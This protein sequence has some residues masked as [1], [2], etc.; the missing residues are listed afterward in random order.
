YYINKNILDRFNFSYDQNAEVS[1]FEENNHFI[2][3][4]GHYTYINH[5][6]ENNLLETLLKQFQNS[7][8]SFL[9]TLDYIGGRYVV[10]IGNESKVEVYP[11]ATSSRTT[12]YSEDS[13][14]ASSHANLL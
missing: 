4:H 10:V 9:D 8:E 13:I 6:K 5:H 2:I 11:D 12:Y 14:L 7:Y 3:I 1:Y